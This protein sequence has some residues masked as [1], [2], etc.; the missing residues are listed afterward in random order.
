MR[1][2]VHAA[3]LEVD[4]QSQLPPPPCINL[5]QRPKEHKGV[6]SVRAL[7]Y[8]FIY[9][10]GCQPLLFKDLTLAL[11]SNTNVKG[12]KKNQNPFGKLIRLCKLFRFL[13]QL[14]VKSSIF[15]TR[16]VFFLLFSFSSLTGVFSGDKLWACRVGLT[17]TLRF[18]GRCFSRMHISSLMRT[19]VWISCTLPI[20][21]C[22]VL[23][24][25]ESNKDLARKLILSLQGSTQLWKSLFEPEILLFVPILRGQSSDRRS[26]AF[27]C[28]FL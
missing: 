4:S 13:M 8:L 2:H 21:P 14:L 25:K 20:S 12:K 7:F 17:R 18:R 5:L 1:L 27:M 15:Y 22:F 10:Q 11:Q 26:A 19:M 9:F 23:Q 3:L 24:P 28:L 16:I 6:G